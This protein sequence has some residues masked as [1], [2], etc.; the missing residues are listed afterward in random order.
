MILFFVYFIIYGVIKIDIKDLLC[1]NPTSTENEK[2]ILNLTLS[3]VQIFVLEIY[4]NQCMF[5]YVIPHTC[6]INHNILE[7]ISV[8]GI[9]LFP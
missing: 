3:I 1:K 7:N 6:T 9:T 4:A 8:T 2:R 5:Y